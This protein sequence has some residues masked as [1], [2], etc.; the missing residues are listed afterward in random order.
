LRN[1]MKE[2]G[3]KTVWGNILGNGTPIDLAPVDFQW[4]PA[5]SA[6]PCDMDATLGA[7]IWNKSMCRYYRPCLAE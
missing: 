1:G 2:G 4:F 7:L 3:L 5:L 6:G